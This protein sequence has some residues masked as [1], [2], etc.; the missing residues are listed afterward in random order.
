[1]KVMNNIVGNEFLLYTMYISVHQTCLIPLFHAVH[2]SSVRRSRK[3]AHMHA[4]E[5]LINL[6]TKGILRSG[7]RQVRPSRRLCHQFVRTTRYAKPH[8][9]CGPGFLW[10]KRSDRLRR[11]KYATSLLRGELR[12]LL[13][14]WLESAI[15]AH[16]ETC[17]LRYIKRRLVLRLNLEACWLR[18]GERIRQA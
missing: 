7:L 17:W 6:E 14:L 18:S 13:N 15:H 10:Y 5:N 9:R 4:V 11:S 8:G 3:H 1:M 16:A 2:N 12:S